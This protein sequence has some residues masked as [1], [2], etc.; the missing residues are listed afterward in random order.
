MIVRTVLYRCFARVASF[1]AFVS[2]SPTSSNK[3]FCNSFDNIDGFVY[4][5][6]WEGRGSLDAVGGSHVSTRLNCAVCLVTCG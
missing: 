6:M 2:T 4:K 5:E 1:T 3:A